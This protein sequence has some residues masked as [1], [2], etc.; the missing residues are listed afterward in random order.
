MTVCE[1]I[2]LPSGDL[3]TQRPAVAQTV[4]HPSIFQGDEAPDSS[5]VSSPAPQPP[6]L[7]ASPRRLQIRPLNPP[8]ESALRCP[9]PMRPSPP[10]EPTVLTASSSC[11][12]LVSLCCDPRAVLEPGGPR[13]WKETQAFLFGF[14]AVSAPEACK[15]CPGWDEGSPLTGSPVAVGSS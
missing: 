3:G 15:S 14:G 2:L 10:G 1:A 6:I 11:A 4:V 9:H 7:S 8:F 13:S 12:P 5:S